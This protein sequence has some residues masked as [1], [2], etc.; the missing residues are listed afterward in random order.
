MPTRTVGQP[1]GRPVCEEGDTSKAPPKGEAERWRWPSGGATLQSPP[2]TKVRWRSSVLRRGALI[3]PGR[4]ELTCR[5]DHQVR[6]PQQRGARAA[7]Q[8]IGARCA[9]AMRTMAVRTIAH[10][11]RID[12]RGARVEGLE[13]DRAQKRRRALAVSRQHRQPAP[14]ALVGILRKQRLRLRRCRGGAEAVQR[15]C[16]RV[17][18]RSRGA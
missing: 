6:A 13:E 1:A 16:R 8:R 5:G 11:E 15:R 9:M 10:K 4:Y 7:L 3:M 14:A 2:S 17:Q 12:E 18:E